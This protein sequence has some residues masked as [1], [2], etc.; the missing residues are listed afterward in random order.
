VDAFTPRL[1]HQVDLL[2]F[3][4]PYVP[5]EDEEARSAQSTHG[6]A[7]AWAGGLHGMALTNILL[8]R[9]SVYFYTCSQPPYDDT[10]STGAA[11][12]ERSLLSCCYQTE[13]RTWHT[14]TNARGTRSPLQGQSSIST[15]ILHHAHCRSDCTP[16][17]SR[18]RTPFC[19]LFHSN[20]VAVGN[21]IQNSVCRYRFSAR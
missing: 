11:I 13:R 9:I 19:A 1:H 7:G 4:P 15:A 21:P 6:I 12:D 10:K 2:L 14:A 17:K 8:S 18:W 16:A 5:T 20:G 3:N